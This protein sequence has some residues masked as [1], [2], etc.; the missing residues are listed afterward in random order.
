VQWL[1]VSD[2]HP[3]AFA[4]PLLLAAWLFL[5]QGRLLP[6]ALFA[7][8]AITTKEHVGLAV[9]GLGVWYAL[10]YREW[11]RGAVIAALA[12]GAALV[13]ALLVVPHFAAAGTSAFESRYDVPSLDGRDLG[14]LLRLLL[15]LALLPLA[16]PLPLVAALPELGLNLLSSTVTQTSIRTHYAATLVPPLLVATVFAVARLGRRTAFAA[17]AA[18]A[19]GTVA[20]GPIGRVTVAAD[21]HDEALRRAVALVPPD[22]PVSATNHLGAHLSARDSVF[23]FPMRRGATW[24]AVDTRRL[25]YL[26]SLRPERARPALAALRRDP[27]WRLVS[28]QDG[29]LVFRRRR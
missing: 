21:A 11:G 12:G 4:C 5:D 27:K 23:S 2:F 20:L 14:Y 9:A 17:A 10:R 16:A 26:D 19:V 15:A 28:A 6:F 25:T 7:A 22:A 3:V 18:A 1:T 13:A 24:V 29:V 8:A